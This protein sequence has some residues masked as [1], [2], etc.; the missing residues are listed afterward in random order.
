MLLSYVH[1]HLPDKCQ[2]KYMPSGLDRVQSSCT[3]IKKMHFCLHFGYR[4]CRAVACAQGPHKLSRLELLYQAFEWQC[5]R[6]SHS[7]QLNATQYK[8]LAYTT[9]HNGHTT[10][11]RQRKRVR[12]FFSGAAVVVQ[13]SQVH[14]RTTE[15]FSNTQKKKDCAESERASK[16]AREKKGVQK[17]EQDCRSK[18]NNHLIMQYVHAAHT[19]ADY[20]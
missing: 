5:S 14:Q 1:V 4:V 8:Q 15:Q 17:K 11:L 10:R 3:S 2:T 7:T 18:Q 16:R 12:F 9:D 20:T 6:N 13:E 19:R